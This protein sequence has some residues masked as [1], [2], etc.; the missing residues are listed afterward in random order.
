MGR[1]QPL[2]CELR[3]APRF[4]HKSALQAVPP[5][6][7]AESW[8]PE[9]PGCWALRR[10]PSFCPSLHL[11]ACE[12]L[13]GTGSK[14]SLRKK[15]SEP[16]SLPSGS[17]C[18]L[19]PGFPGP[20]LSKGPDRARVPSIPRRQELGQGAS[21][22]PAPS[23]RTQCRH[24][25]PHRPSKELPLPSGRRWAQGRSL[26]IPSKTMLA[27]RFAASSEGGAREREGT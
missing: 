19:D 21:P 25:P 7:R 24:P 18:L 23:Q 11:P 1:S 10:R 2:I 20:S 3:R 6:T 9:S 16:R 14:F 27:Q 22:G 15:R 8:G 26:G 13:G 12:G 5:R 4:I 17:R